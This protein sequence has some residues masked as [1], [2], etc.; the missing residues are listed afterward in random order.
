MTQT[1]VASGTPISTSILPL[2]GRVLIAALFLLSGTG[3]IAQPSA[4][5]AYIASAG[6]P[7]PPLA[8]AGAALVELG[9]GIALVLGYRTRLTATVLAVFSILAALLF[10]SALSDQ[11]Q[12]IHFFK[13]LSIAGGLLQVIAFGGGRYSVDARS[14]RLRMDETVRLAI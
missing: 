8:W 4:T 9:G 3:K 13:N 2:A 14:D 1:T 12:F 6:L 11:N 5:M 7:F 10:H